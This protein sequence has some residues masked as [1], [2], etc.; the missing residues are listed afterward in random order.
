MSKKQISLKLSTV[1]L[2]VLLASCGGG[3]SD[4]Y[5]NE[6]DNSQGNGNGNSADGNNSTDNT[7]QIAES[8]NVLDLKDAEGKV[9]VNANDSSVVQFTVQVLNKDNGGVA[10]K[11]V[12]LSI[13]DSEKLG[14]TSKA[15]LV[16]TMEGGFALFELNIPTLNAASG[17]VQL[18][19]TVKGTSINQVYTLNIVK[20]ATIQSEYNLNVDQGVVLNLPK[21]NATINARVTDKNGGIKA[22]QTV[23][24]A[25]PPQMQDKFSITSG[26]SV[27]TDE[28]GNARFTITSNS[29]LTAKEIE[30]FTATS[31][32]LEFNL[33]DE[34]QSQKK[35]KAA[36]TFKDISQVVQKLEIIKADMPIAAQGGT[37]TVKVRAKNTNDV[38]LANKKVQLQFSDKSDA[39]GVTVDPAEAM[40]D[41]NGYATFTIKSNSSYPIALSQQG[42]N[43]KAVYAESSE[44]FA[45]ET[46]TVITTNETADDQL[47]L[48]RLEIDSSYKISAKNDKVKITV[49]GINNKGV[50]ATKGKVTLSL[51]EEATSNGVTFDGS[52]TQEFKDGYVTFTLYTNAKTE[53]A[54][55][56]LVTTGITASFKTDNDISN[57]IKITVEDEAKS[58]EAVG[59]LA[60]DPLKN[61]FDY[62]KDQSISVKVKAVGV[63]GSALQG[64]NLAA[65][66]VGLS[67]AD[68][69][70]L[71]LTLTHAS[72]Q[73]TDATGYATFIYQYKANGSTKQKELTTAG[74]RILVSGSNDSQQ[75]V[76][77]NF[78]APTDVDTVD[79]DYLAVDM[80]SGN[81]IL[82]Q[83]VEQTLTVVVNATDTN[84]QAYAGQKVGVGLSDAA[85]SNGVSLKT[86]SA[87][88]TNAQ[89][90][91]T[92]SLQVKANSA[93][94]LNNLIANGITI[95]VKGTRQDGS[96][97]TLTRKIEVTQPVIVLPNLAGLSL[98]YDVQT[99]SV[100]GGEVKI[101][102][103]A[104]DQAGQPIPNTPLVIA[105][106]GLTSSRASLSDTNLITNSKGEAEFTIKVSEGAYDASLIKNGIT[107][108]VVGSN[109][110]NNDRIQQTGTI[111]VVIPKDSV[112]LRLNADEKNLELGKTYA[113]QIAV[114]DELGANTAYPVNLSLNKEAVDAG[115]RLASDS[116][117]TS[118]NGTAPVSII[119]PKN[120]PDA[121]KAQLL[122]A[123]IQVTGSITN[124]KGEALKAVLS[125][126]VYEA[127]NL[128]HLE[129]VSSKADLSTAGD[130]SIVTVRLLDQNNQPV[131]NQDVTLSA[132]NSAT[133]IVGT[134]G[135]GHLTNTS[136]PQTV[137]TD[138]NGNAFFALEL[139][140]ATLDADLL[141]ASG[142]E[143][144]AV[145]TDAAGAVK[146][147]ITRLGAFTP[148][149]GAPL[150]PRYNLRIASS[151][152]SLNVRNDTADVTVTLV[153]A[154]GGGVAEKYVRLAIEN[155]VL[156]GTI[157]EGASGLTTDEKGKAVFKI[158]IDE[159]A[160]RAGY[161]AA[162][163]ISQDLQLAA[164]FSE[165]GYNEAQQITQIDVVPSAV[166]NPV[167]SIVIGVNPTET[168]S[169]SDGVYYTKN[170]S[171]SV[172]D[173]DGKPLAKQKVE[174]DITPTVYIKGQYKWV[175]APVLGEA[176]AAKWVGAG[177]PYYDLDNPNI[178]LD[179][180][181]V[182]TNNNGTP[183]DTRDDYAAAPVLNPIQFCRADST[184]AA[185]TNTQVTNIPVKVPTFLGQGTTATYTT[186]EEGK[187]D[188]TIRYPKIYAQWLN[189]RIGA[190]STVATLPFR[191]TYNLGL[192]SVNS[193]YSTDG[194]YGPN[195][196]S[197]YGTSTTTC[198]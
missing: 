142:I 175:L 178:Y 28:K 34:N 165:E 66:L 52:N 87:L 29:D 119:V 75:T 83:G 78:K 169:S 48:Q 166:V 74:I 108:A 116:V 162:N 133:L 14:V 3:G 61:A 82:T 36:L 167:A 51:N 168:S 67:T 156:N 88:T 27:T 134:P 102:V 195:L 80:S 103:V 127:I 13:K 50:A 65:K 71:G 42:I 120:I 101:K 32:S 73:T 135:D 163:F 174:M 6:K 91:V 138:S 145:H 164:Y 10:E 72:T 122:T 113:V 147:Q 55:T 85:L 2:A 152:S 76:S 184:G 43:L 139:D 185:V 115:V 170:L 153:D 125:F 49:K 176:P 5:F 86:A 128:N 9:I 194:S 118:A 62:T 58:E 172:V 150:A 173:F 198:P 39:Y 187:F 18:T 177:E 81:L 19:A 69:Q 129:I 33:I 57:S 121:V 107:F 100:L 192:P 64:E 158:K 11:D 1:A 24:L 105:V 157:I 4:G 196:D 53:A 149:P 22:G 130:K 114:K 84:G 59:F 144:T 97:Y 63:Q 17:K 183:S 99:V 35:V 79:L 182:P 123:G 161:T 7:A 197:P 146:T 189:V 25:L 8:L 20:K 109:L 31:Q 181:G 95:A 16:K 90:K 21:G 148:A 155:N 37:T 188:L 60:I 89:G 124:P 126:T 15:S 143:L 70:A 56:A 171:V 117:L 98:S 111:Q 77:L 141:R 41:T 54:V 47:A 112:N 92:F 151:K 104:K 94:E 131:K 179:T 68:L 30:E 96:A 23:V 191:T 106:S 137:K 140:A 40:T 132:N 180:S 110:N 46:I 12:I 186:D 45:Q 193:D 154:N 38:A 190:S 26:S 44:V 159:A 136:T 93:S 160:R